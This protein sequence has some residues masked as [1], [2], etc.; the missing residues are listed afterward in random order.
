MFIRFQAKRFST[1]PSH[2]SR[3]IFSGSTGAI[4]VLVILARVFTTEEERMSVRDKVIDFL[5]FNK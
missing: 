2:P 5:G 1:L 4:I 3:P